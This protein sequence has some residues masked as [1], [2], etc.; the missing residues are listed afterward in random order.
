MLKVTVTA[1]VMPS[2][3]SVSGSELEP[4]LDYQ[5]GLRKYPKENMHTDWLKIVLI[6]KRL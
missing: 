5:P 6:L 3:G 4:K 2:P 1:A